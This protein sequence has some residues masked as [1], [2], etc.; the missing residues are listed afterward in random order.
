[1][2]GD[3][4]L[5][6]GFLNYINY[7]LI[8]SLNVTSNFNLI[9]HI[10]V[11]TVHKTHQ[12]PWIDINNTCKSLTAPTY[13]SKNIRKDCRFGRY[14]LLYPQL[15]IIILLG[16]R[17]YKSQLWS[18]AHKTTQ[19]KKDE[20]MSC[21]SW[22]NEPPFI[23]EFTHECKKTM[24]RIKKDHERSFLIKLLTDMLLA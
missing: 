5:S 15:S 2:K 24:M 20:G 16:W 11:H 21:D 1:M 4:K 3:I 17:Y 14:P 22:L 6:L 10:I 19:A 13:P 9:L 7:L 12:V 23:S 18:I 8:Q